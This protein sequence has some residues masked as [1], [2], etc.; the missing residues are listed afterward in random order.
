MLSTEIE[1][2]KQFWFYLVQSAYFASE[3]SLL[4]AN[5]H[6]SCKSSLANLNP[7][8]QKHLIKVG[9]RL[10]NTI[11]DEASMHPVILPRSSPFTKLLIQQSHINCLHGGTQLTLATLRQEVWIVRGRNEVRKEIRMCVQC[12]RYAAR[13]PTQLM[14]DLPTAHVRSSHTFEKSGVDYA[15]PI[16]VRLTKTRGKGTMKGYVC[17]FVCMVTKACHLELVEDLTSDAFIAA[18]HRFT[19][20]RG[21]CKELYSDCGTNFI[22]ADTQLQRMLNE[23]SEFQSHLAHSLADLG[24]EWKF[25]PPS[26]PHFDGLWEAAVKSLK[27]HLKTVIGDQVLTFSEL[28]TLLCRVEACLNSR[29]LITL[30]DDSSDIRILTPAHFTVQR[31]SYLVP[32]LD[33]ANDSIPMGKR[34]RLLSQMMQQFW[35]SWNREYLTSLQ[36]RTK[37]LKIKPAPEIGDVVLIRNENSPPGKW[38]MG[39]IIELHP[40]VDEIVRVVTLQTSSGQLRRPIVKLVFLPKIDKELGLA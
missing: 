4:L 33:L 35:H 22:G 21:R 39:R 40:G 8:I 19:S 30:S 13:T 26:A 5:K 12:T 2:A 38:P 11:L 10:S 32:E 3:R 20:R 9:G 17:V 28:A 25:N 34:W 16:S 37:L 23:C 24:T 18:F 14:G 29:P 7:F 27:F 15:G 31:S 1:N 6:L 36:T